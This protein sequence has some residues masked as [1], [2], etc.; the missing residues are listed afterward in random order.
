MSLW[1]KRTDRFSE[2]LFHVSSITNV[3]SQDKGRF[4]VFFRKKHYDFLA[5]NDEVKE[6]WVTSLLATRGTPG[7]TPPELH[8]QITLKDTRRSTYAAV[9][10]HDLW[11]YP[12]KESFQLGVASFSVPLNVASVKQMGKHSFSLITPY[13]SFNCSVDSSKDL[14]T[15]VSS[16]SSTIQS[17]LSCSQVALRLWENPYNK[18]CGDCGKANPEWASVNLLLV[19]C[20]SCAGQHRALSANLSKVRSL[21]MDSKVWTEPLVQLFLLYGNGLANQVWAPAVPA[22]EQLRPE[23]SEEERSKFIQDKYSRGR[24]RRVHALTSSRSMMDQRLCQVVCSDDE[25]EETMSLICSGAK[26]CPSDPQSP[27]P[28]LLAE[29]ANQALQTELLRLNKYTEV[30]LHKPQTTRRRLDSALSGEEEEELH[31]KLEEDRFLFSL[32]NDSAACDVLDLREVLSVFLKDGVDH[33]FELVTLSEQLVCNADDE[34]TLLNHLIHILKVILPGGVSYAEVGRA[35][36]VSKVCMVEV[37]G[38]SSQMDAWLLLWEEGVSVHPINT[39]KQQALRIELS[40]LSNHE[41]D[42]AENIITMATTDRS[43]SLRFEEQYSCRTWLT[44]LQRALTNQFSVPRRP[45]A[46]QTLYPVIDGGFRGSVPAAIERC[47]S[48]ITTYGLKV[49]GVYR[50][51]G[52]ATKVKQLVEV[53]MTSPNTAPLESNEQ[54]VLDTGSA[55]K[56]YIRQQQNLIPDGD[57]KQWQQAAGITDERSRFKKYR[58]LLRQLPDSNRATLNALFGHFY[59]VQVFSQVNKMSAHNLA[60]VLVPSL[61]QAMN[62]DLILLTREFI[63]HHTLLFLTPGG[64]ARQEEEEITVL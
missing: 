60:V 7:P 24:Y 46:H 20:Q 13:K 3:K 45:P 56:Q 58:R 32:E 12:N 53:L 27:S 15:W 35:L 51:C 33:Q 39:H 11:I 57:R 16:L 50:R 55:L 47:I 59:M 8:G 21:K 49:E 4:S 44:H 42:P 52:L 37:G 23:S 43:M 40:M 48:H 28:I 41:M 6:G 9:W 22:A 63:I 17:A 29:R 54:G 34:E 18:V 5:H 38:A 64:E 10:G 36:A 25:I 1:K 31:G 30:P 26:V 14:S 62:Q 2:V 19:I 61:F